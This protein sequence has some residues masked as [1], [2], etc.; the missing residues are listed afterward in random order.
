MSKS[1]LATGHFR[2]LQPL[3]EKP[4]PWN[5]MVPRGEFPGT[6]DIP[7]GYDVPGFG[8][9]E[10][11]MSI[12][13]ITVIGDTQLERMV[14]AFE[15]EMLI[16]PDH[17]SHD[18]THNTEAMGWG[19]QIRFMPNREGLEVQTEWTDLGREKILKKIYR[20]ISPEFD[21]HVRYEDGVFKFYPIALTGAGLTN[22]PKLKTLRPVSANRETNDQTKPTMKAALTLLCGL[23]GAPE[24]ATE[25]E[26]TTKVEAFKGDLAT[27]KNRADGATRIEEENKKLKEEAVTAD[28][29]RFADVI[30]DK[31]SAKLLLQTN[32]DATVKL[33]TAAQAKLGGDP[34]KPLYQK[35]RA[36]PPD[37]S[38]FTKDADEEEKKE[39]AR[40]ALVATVRNR[41]K[42][43]FQT[44][45][46]IAKGEKP[47]LFTETPEA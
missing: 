25:Q 3:A 9:V 22:R 46:S 32:R 5:Q 15:G 30:E 8:I 45:W 24:T 14:Q 27:Q 37:G 4:A 36:T 31:D 12:E 10:E 13:G 11:D 17:L 21:G 35:N 42:C 34:R 1:L 20:F 26:L 38:K 47:E 33:F 44:A 19:H 16:D 40:T 18:R 23:I 7:A 39:S 28:L 41:E 29:E 43:D 6:I 2:D